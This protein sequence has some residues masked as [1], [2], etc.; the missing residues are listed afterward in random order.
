MYFGMEKNTWET[1]DFISLLIA[2]K[3]RLQYD[4]EDTRTR[5]S[6]IYIV[7]ASLTCCTFLVL[8]WYGQG[9]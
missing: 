8:S 7:K 3:M 4:T 2:S 6:H 9:Q 5:M 1:C